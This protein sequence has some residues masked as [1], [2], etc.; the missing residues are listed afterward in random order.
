M[1]SQ[2][3]SKL[4]QSTQSRHFAFKVLLPILQP[5]GYRS[6]LVC[7]T[8]SVASRVG[9][10]SGIRTHEI[11]GYLASPLDAADL[12]RGTCWVVQQNRG[13]SILSRNARKRVVGDSP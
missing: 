4:K 5:C 10:T 3:M 7:D 12:A 6:S 13:D 9:G 8:L 1:R 2:K 11:D